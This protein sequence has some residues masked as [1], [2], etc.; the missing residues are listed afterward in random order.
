MR[1]ITCNLENFARSKSSGKDTWLK[2]EKIEALLRIKTK[3]Q[4]SSTCSSTRNGAIRACCEFSLI[5]SFKQFFKASR[6]NAAREMVAVAEASLESTVGADAQD[7]LAWA[8]MLNQAT[9]KVNLAEL[10]RKEAAK[11]HTRKMQKLQEIEV[12]QN[13]FFIS[14]RVFQRTMRSLQKSQKRSIISSKPYFELKVIKMAEMDEKRYKVNEIEQKLHISKSDYQA[15]LRTLETISEQ[16]HLHRK[17]QS[18]ESNLS[19]CVNG[20]F[21]Q[22]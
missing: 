12:L 22:F 6:H 20:S 5:G 3:I 4:G 8:E 2:C 11:L 17:L 15:A 9:E 14:N 7:K 18:L 21:L 1:K 16:I 10:E 13:L 19:V